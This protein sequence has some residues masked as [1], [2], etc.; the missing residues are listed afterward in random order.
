MIMSIINDVH[1]TCMNMFHILP[2]PHH[3]SHMLSYRGV[4][5]LIK[6]PSGDGFF[7]TFLFRS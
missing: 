3:Y 1:E 4:A 7:I 2:S 6:K 5:K